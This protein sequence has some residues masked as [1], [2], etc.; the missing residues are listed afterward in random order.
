MGGGWRPGLPVADGG[1]GR[2]MVRL[3][4]VG[5]RARLLEALVTAAVVAGAVVG[6]VPG[7]AAAPAGS[8][9]PAALAAPTVRWA[10]VSGSGAHTCAVRVDHSLWCWGQNVAG[11]LGD[12]TT[13]RRLARVRVVASARWV[14]VAAGGWHTCGSGPMAACGA[15]V[16]TTWGAR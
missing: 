8:A 12:G 4:K 1:R 5:R 3:P 16:R 15:G 10:S 11:Q 13:T 14:S 6:P 9:F 2:G 7:S